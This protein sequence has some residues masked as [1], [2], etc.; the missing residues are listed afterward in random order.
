MPTLLQKKLN[1]SA[2]LGIWHI[3]ERELWFVEQLQLTP[4]EDQYISE[5]KGRRR[6][7]WL[8]GRWL[9]H[10]LSG[11]TIRGACIKDEHGKPFLENSLLDISISHSRELVAI[12]AGAES[13]GIDIQKVVGKIERIAYKYMRDEELAS[14]KDET[15]LE[16][17][18][19][20]WGAKEALYKAYGRRALEFKV[21]ILIEPFE[22]TDLSGQ[23]TG[24]VVKDD[25]RANFIIDYQ[26]IF[27][28]ENGFSFTQPASAD[29]ILDRYILVYAQETK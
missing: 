26:Q 27:R 28:L 2:H 17:L 8:A 22:L 20:Y 13:V 14:L 3:T 29:E 12:M 19:I 9:L 11:R 4:T 1:H 25:F 23:T 16:Q 6:L 24:R 10:H 15:R 21:H 5:L 7:E 18:H